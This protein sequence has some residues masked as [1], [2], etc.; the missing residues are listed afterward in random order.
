MT[1]STARQAEQFR[2][3]LDQRQQ[4]GFLCDVDEWRV[5]PDPPGGRVGSGGSTIHV[6]STL[7]GEDDADRSLRNRRTLILHGGGKS[8]RMPAYSICGKLF[9]PLPTTGNSVL[10]TTLFD[11]QLQRYMQL[12][13]RPGGQVI[14]CAGDVLLDFDADRVRLDH[15]GLTGVATHVSPEEA[16]EH[17]VFADVRRNGRVHRYLQKPS[18]ST[19][20][21]Q[22]AINAGGQA[23]I[24]LGIM[25]FSPHFAGKLIDVN[26]QLCARTEYTDVVPLD[27]YTEICCALGSSDFPEYAR[28]V[29]EHGASDLDE[30]A[31][32]LIRDSLGEE[33]FFCSTVPDCQFLHFGT[34]ADYLRSAQQLRATRTV[35]SPA[36]HSDPLIINSRLTRSQVNGRDAWVEGTVSSA[37]LRLD[38]RNLLVG[39]DLK[40]PR[41][42]R[43]GTCLDV[44][45]GET[46]EEE[47]VYFYR[48]YG[49]DD[50]FKGRLEQDTCTFLNH[51][52]RTWLDRHGVSEDDV[53]GDIPQADRSLWNARLFPASPDPDANDL[54][55]WMQE[56]SARSG[57]LQRWKERRRYSVMEIAE[58][59]DWRRFWQRRR[60]VRTDTLIHTLPHCVLSDEEFSARELA[61]LLRSADDPT[62]HCVQLLESVPDQARALERARILHT[63]GSVLED[64][65]LPGREMERVKE[66]FRAAY[67]DREPEGHLP[68][69]LKSCA[70]DTVRTALVGSISP[71]AS[72][73]QRGIKTD[74]IVWGRAPVRLD[75]AGG[76]T[77]TP[78]YTLEHGGSVVNVAANLNG[79]PPIQAFARLCDQ[80]RIK[81]SSIDLGITETITTLDELGAYRDP[82]GEFSIARAALAL[83][84][85]QPGNEVW[86]GPDNL[87]EMLEAFGGG[88]ELTTLCAVPK[89]SGLGTSSIL[90]AVLLATVRRLL[91]SEPTDRELFHQVLV[92]EQMLTTGGGWQDQIGGVIGGVKLIST[93]PGMEPDPEIR[94]L[95]PEILCPSTN[96]R[97]T[98]LYYTGVTRLAKNILQQVVGRYLDREPEYLRCMEQLAA[99]CSHVREALERRDAAQLGATLDRVWETNK[100]LD[101]NSTN[102]RVEEIMDRVSEYV[103]GAKLLG[104]GGGGFMLMVCPD[105]EAARRCR[106]DLEADPPND[107]ARFYDF[108]VNDR[109]LE[110]TVS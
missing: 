81:L 22:G 109:G 45:P 36:V 96:E 92:L 108:R 61:H 15:D 3:L 49:I 89:G 33:P 58:R 106:E 110:V 70:A 68:E 54:V 41:R 59:A 34:S 87:E 83:C 53:W 101:P 29:A 107:L 26:K 30:S 4:L 78:P 100:R 84:G 69:T 104:A 10:P 32:R 14:I 8:R 94:W 91:G 16:C 66:A 18:V 85:F 79:Q 97:R 86:N 21:Q 50:T 102:A 5:I 28:T 20:D 62:R 51:P 63:L 52:I 38:G 39:A 12:P 2:Y 95:H 67:P 40:E 71:P 103:A 64:I 88:I 23:A 98:L 44:I 57:I 93:D 25:S 11:L 72:R 65:D 82:E 6:L 35:G 56:E 77:D 9:A 47:P 55:L 17:G 48:L 24:D 7:A 76:W 42:L 13:A 60:A 74:E 90:G 31:L 46:E 105:E 27:F 75:L 43:E 1:A 73:P 80:P 19:V 37:D 99:E